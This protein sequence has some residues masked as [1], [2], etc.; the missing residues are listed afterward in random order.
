[1]GPHYANFRA[2]TDDLLAHDAIRI[3]EKENLAKV[4]VDLL[5]NR[6]AAKAMGDRAHQVFAQQS[7]ATA[8][9]MDALKELLAEG[10]RTQ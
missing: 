8:R 4:L 7:G 6:T 1:M 2:I 10:A 3:T 9:C 5:C